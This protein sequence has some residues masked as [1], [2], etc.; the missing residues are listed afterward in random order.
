M[1]G[2]MRLITVAFPSAAAFLASYDEG[3]LFARTRTDAVLGETVLV[4]ISFRGLPNRTL[5]RAVVEGLRVD[6]EGLKLR[7]SDD[8]ASTRDFMVALA[9]GDVRIESTVH[10]DHKR[11]P[12]ALPVEYTVAGSAEVRYSL[13]DDLGAGGCFILAGSSPTVGT[14][15]LLRIAAPDGADLRVEGVVAWVR[16]GG[17]GG[18]GVD[19]DPVVG[20]SGRRLRTLLR[21]AR[22]TGDVDLDRTPPSRAEEAERGISGRVESGIIG[23]AD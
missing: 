8:D 22:E 6:E 2:R 12:A 3:T 13:V 9:R 20:E 15:V 18:F 17:G 7:I 19:F 11:F 1:I 23:Q 5:V 4:E 21:R 14:R 16:E 10:R